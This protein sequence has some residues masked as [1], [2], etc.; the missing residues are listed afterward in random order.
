M[1]DCAVAAELYDRFPQLS[2]G[3]LTR[4]RAALVREETLA[5]V[6]REIG[7][8]AAIRLGEGELAASAEPRPSILADA[9]EALI[10]AVFLDGGYPAARAVVLSLLARRFGQ[11]DAEGPSK[12]AKTELQELLQAE[13][14]PLPVY[15]VL[16]VQGAAHQQSFEIECVVGDLTASGTGRSRQKAEQEAA[17]AMLDKLAP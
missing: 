5:E 8:T 12:D 6:A 3:K 11:L 13:R 7:L 17:R 15:R 1:L 16:S 9:L 2:E 10:G 4:L 14:R